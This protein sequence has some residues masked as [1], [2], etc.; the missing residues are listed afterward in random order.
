MFVAKIISACF[1]SALATVGM[2]VVNVI[3]TAVSMAL[4]EKAGRRVL[5]L[6]GLGGMFVAAVVLAVSIR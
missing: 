5:H 4:I 6:V 2:G 3:M 1:Y